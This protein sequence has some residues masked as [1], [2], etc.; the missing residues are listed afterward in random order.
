MRTG[1]DIGKAL[2]LGDKQ[3]AEKAFVFGSGYE[4]GEKESIGRS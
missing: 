4:K 1:Y 2:K 3:S